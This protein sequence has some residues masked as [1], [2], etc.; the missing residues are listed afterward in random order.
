MSLDESLELS[1]I[2]PIEARTDL[3]RRFIGWEPIIA[4][5]VELGLYA[6]PIPPSR[7][8]GGRK[9]KFVCI[10]CPFHNDRTPSCALYDDGHF[11]CYGC[12][13]W[14]DPANLVHYVFACSDEPIYSLEA[15]LAFFEGVL[16]GVPLHTGN[17]HD[18]VIENDYP[19]LV[20]LFGNVR[21]P[22]F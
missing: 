8:P 3:C 11:F 14:G 12:K 5:L 17:L 1:E 7:R 10:S 9:S 19:E 21:R 22:V 15:L 18:Q 6:N 16:S 13:R 4:K 2:C 20:D